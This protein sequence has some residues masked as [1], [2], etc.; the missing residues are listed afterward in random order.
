V[1]WRGALTLVLLDTHGKCA[2]LLAAASAHALAASASAAAAGDGDAAAEAALAALALEPLY[3]QLFRDVSTAAR[4]LGGAPPPDAFPSA[5]EF[6][7]SL[8]L[9]RAAAASA[10]RA[11][12]FPAAAAAGACAPALAAFASAAAAPRGA[13]RAAA[14]SLAVRTWELDWD[15]RGAARRTPAHDVALWRVCALP[16]PSRLEALRS[17]VR[18]ARRNAATS[19]RTLGGDATAA[20][21]LAPTLTVRGEPH[22]PP[23]A[24]LLAAADAARAGDGDAAGAAQALLHFLDATSLAGPLPMHTSDAS[25]TDADWSLPLLELA[26]AAA[27]AALG[28]TQP[29]LVPTAWL[30]AYSRLAGGGAAAGK[31]SLPAPQRLNNAP[32]AAADAA[33]GAETSAANAIAALARALRVLLAPRGHG[34]SAESPSSP[35]PRLLRTRRAAL[36]PLCCLLSVTLPTARGGDA[37]MAPLELICWRHVAS[38]AVADADVASRALDADAADPSLVAHALALCRAKPPPPR[39]DV[40]SALFA[41]ASAAAAPG[42]ERLELTLLSPG[43]APLIF[44]RVAPLSSSASRDKQAAV[45]QVTYAAPPAEPRGAAAAA[46]AALLA[47]PSGEALRVFG[48]R[49]AA[50]PS[51]AQHSA[52]CVLQRVWR[53]RA[54]AHAAAALRRRA[55][56]AC[57]AAARGLARERDAAGAALRRWADDVR[58]TIGERRERAE[59]EDFARARAADLSAAYAQRLQTISAAAASPP[60]AAACP[61]CARTAVADA[62]SAA[63]SAANAAAAASSG[64]RAAAFEFVPIAAHVGTAEHGAAAAAFASYEAVYLSEVCPALAA[65]DAVVSDSALEAHRDSLRALLDGIEAR[66]AWRGAPEAVRAALAPLRAAT[67]AIAAWMQAQA[68]QAAQQQLAV[69]AAAARG[70]AGAGVGADGSGGGGLLIFRRGEAAF[71]GSADAAWGNENEPAEAAAAAAVDG[72]EDDGWEEVGRKQKRVGA[73]RRKGG[74]GK[75]GRARA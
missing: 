62:A 46:A 20:A 23:L 12:L 68:A 24:L 10:L 37:R 65:A 60:S 31:G 44:D 6:S 75:K 18:I 57:A 38:L 3:E 58:R 69:R 40:L 14:A 43:A 59:A 1:T 19:A 63:V 33:G 9:R 73:Q 45:L 27:L 28:A 61:L 30:E 70:A 36:L 4:R 71:D 29:V 17:R 15:A 55:A 49:D 16:A 11:A 52:A 8:A 48:A 64:L 34:T 25:A 41:L 47:A 53:A 22:S 66:R 67:A 21:A 2:A 26:A 51:E 35:P 13:P 39:R 56:A 74:G 72:F 42:G 32:A 7:D 54:A 5:R 50:A